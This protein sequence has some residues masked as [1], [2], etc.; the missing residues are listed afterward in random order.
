V[1]I[2]PQALSDKP[3]S[4]WG[5][6]VGGYYLDAGLSATQ[7]AGDIALEWSSRNR[8][9]DG[10]YVYDRADAATDDADFKN[11]ILEIYEGLNLLRTV[12]QTGKAFTYTTAMQTADGGP[13]SAYTFKLKQEGNLAFS[14]QVVFTV[15]IV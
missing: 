12:T 8:F 11:F 13:F 15:D 3:L 9:G 7:E 4:P 14:D 10:M 6:K 1:N 5:I 2:T